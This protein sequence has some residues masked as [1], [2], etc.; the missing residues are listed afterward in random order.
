MCTCACACVCVC[1]PGPHRGEPHI[2]CSSAHDL[3]LF[4][5][6]TVSFFHVNTTQPSTSRNPTDPTVPSTLKSA[7]SF[8]DYTPCP[9]GVQDPSSQARGCLWI[10]SAGPSA[11]AASQPLSVFHKQPLLSLSPSL[12][13][14]TRLKSPGLYLEK[15]LLDLGLAGVRPLCVQ[16]VLSPVSRGPGL[17]ADGTL[18][19]VR[20]A[21]AGFLRWTPSEEGC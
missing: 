4:F 9:T 14:L 11:T 15:T 17:A 19:P 1:A 16:A 10:Q 2:G 6:Q 8:T 18:L 3:T 5:L 20:T 21:P 12:T 7:L 13:I